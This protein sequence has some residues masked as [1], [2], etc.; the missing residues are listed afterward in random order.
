MILIKK[1]KTQKTNQFV[2]QSKKKGKESIWSRGYFDNTQEN[3]PESQFSGLNQS[4]KALCR[5]S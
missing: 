4:T 3:S 5:K 1:I 2:P